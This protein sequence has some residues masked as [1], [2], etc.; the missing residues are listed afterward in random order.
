MDR[1]EQM[2]TV[3]CVERNNVWVWYCHLDL[4]MPGRTNRTMP[5]DDPLY[6]D[7]GAAMVLCDALNM[8]DFGRIDPEPYKG[9]WKG[10]GQ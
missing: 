3:R 10:R 4:D 8:R 2:W 9:Y 5:S 6:A 7:Q 1:I